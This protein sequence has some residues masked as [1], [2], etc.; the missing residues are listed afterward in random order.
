MAELE[1]LRK[2][3]NIL[4]EKTWSSKPGRD[5]QSNYFILI[6]TKQKPNETFTRAILEAI[7]DEFM[8]I[9]KDNLSEIVIFNNNKKRKHFFSHDYIRKVGIKYVVEVG[10]KNGT[11]HIHIALYIDHNSN[12]TIEQGPIYT[13]ANE[14]FLNR[15]GKKPF[16][17]RPRLMTVNRVEEY[18]TKSNQFDEGI[19][20]V[21][22]TS[23][24]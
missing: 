2:E 7:C 6:D 18:M 12:I 17:A 22:V 14:F 21:T 11:V 1:S 3:L 20:W 19:E 9:F 15:L 8:V 13:I 4:K 16:V 10:F 5:A 23:P 24:S